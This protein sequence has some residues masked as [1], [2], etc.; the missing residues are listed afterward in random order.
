MAS[1]KPSVRLKVSPVPIWKYIV[2]NWL[3]F[4]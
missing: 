4:A 1:P 3:E 2:R